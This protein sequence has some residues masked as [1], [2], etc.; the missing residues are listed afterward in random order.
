[1]WCRHGVVRVVCVARAR[2]VRRW[3]D[4]VLVV[5]IDCLLPALLAAGS[6]IARAA[7]PS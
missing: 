5:S 1:M 2:G 6:P 7:L 4:G 3:E